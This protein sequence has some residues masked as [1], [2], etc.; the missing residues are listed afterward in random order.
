V[1]G[2][3]RR[4]IAR[5]AWTRP[6]PTKGVPFLRPHRILGLTLAA[7]LLAVSACGGDDDSN[8]DAASSQESSSQESSSGES[9]GASS[10][11]DL[12]DVPD[13]V[14][15]VNG[16]ELGKDEFVDNY[17]AQFQQMSMQA[18]SSGQPVDEEQL[19][20]QVVD[21]MVNG[22][23]LVQEAEDRGF[24]A[25]QQQTDKAL[26]D[27]AQQN[28]LKSSD[29]FVAALEKQGMDAETVQSQVE[30]Q[31]MIDQLLAST[32]G[33]SEPSEKDLRAYYD[34]LKKQQEQAGGQAGQK[35]PPFDKVKSQLAD[36]LKSQQEQQVAGALIQKLRKDADIEVHL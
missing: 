21:N 35:I 3:R 29:E 23:L 5:L 22:E 7:A 19:K 2:I 12:S 17:E 28:G 15:E 13:V 16:E 31:V 11:P 30:E 20:K 33:G 8:G 10:E 36:Q 6:S 34:D 1:V 4:L 14:A 26:E 25:S 32:G 27:L 24:D 9:Q 18:Q